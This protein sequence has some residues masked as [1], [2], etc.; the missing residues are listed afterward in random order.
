MATVSAIVI[1]TGTSAVVYNLSN[2]L[3]GIQDIYYGSKGREDESANPVLSVF[4]KIIPDR[5][6]AK[7][8][9]HLWG[10]SNTLVANLMLPVSKSLNIAK[11]RGLNAFSAAKNI[12][13]AS[14]TTLAKALAAG[15]G[16]NIVISSMHTLLEKLQK[17]Q[18]N[19]SLGGLFWLY[20]THNHV[21]KIVL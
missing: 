14:V 4:E 19:R 16:A 3:E 1:T 7:Y 9:Y 10:A 13:R 2:M 20:N 8:I 15:V 18:R 21:Q 5:E 6:T 17:G 11:V 12:I